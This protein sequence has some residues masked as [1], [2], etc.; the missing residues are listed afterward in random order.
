MGINGTNNI[1]IDKENYIDINSKMGLITGREVKISMVNRE[2]Y[3]IVEFDGNGVHKKTFDMM[4]SLISQ[5][6]LGYTFLS[7]NSDLFEI[8]FTFTK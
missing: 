3:L 2:E 1:T 4:I 8:S 7:I 6:K 5:L